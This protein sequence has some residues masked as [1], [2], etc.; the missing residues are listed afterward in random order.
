[1]LDRSYIGKIGKFIDLLFCQSPYMQQSGLILLLNAKKHS[2]LFQEP[3][4]TL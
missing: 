3:E 2:I 1:M 4:Y